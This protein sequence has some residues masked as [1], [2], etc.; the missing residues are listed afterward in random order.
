MKARGPRDWYTAH[1]N[2]NDEWIYNIVPELVEP[3][4]R[5]FGLK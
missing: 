5:S 4:K 2:S 1:K 3:L